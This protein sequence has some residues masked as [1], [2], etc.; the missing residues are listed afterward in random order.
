LKK[1]GNARDT[2][3]QLEGVKSLQWALL[4]R[5]RDFMYHDRTK[6][7]QDV[8]LTAEKSCILTA[9]SLNTSMKNRSVH[10]RTC[11]C[12]NR[13]HISISLESRT[14]RNS[15]TIVNRR[16]RHDLRKYSFCNR[17]IN[18][19][20]SLPEDIVAAPSVNSFK[21]R[22]DKRWFSREFKYN[23]Q[24]EIT[25][26]G[27]RSK[28]INFSYLRFLYPDVG[29]EVC[30]ALPIVIGYVMLCYVMQYALLSKGLFP[31]RLR[32]AARCER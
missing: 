10:G 17:I 15:L 30:L 13:R 14:R 22:L 11:L 29:F 32:C 31:L 8:K 6:T 27:S 9:R 4:G 1:N 21:N 23:W 12:R 2:A 25:G 20:N 3:P 5:R 28:V 7:R 24:A 26:T 18:V 16:C 19:W